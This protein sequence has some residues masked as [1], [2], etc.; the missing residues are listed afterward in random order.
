MLQTSR[1]C[2]DT[3]L[4]PYRLVGDATA[5]AAIQVWL[6]QQDR[7]AAGALMRLLTDY[8]NLSLETLPA[9]LADFV[10][11]EVD[12][13]KAFERP[14]FERGIAFFWKHYQAIALLLG[15]YSLPYCYAAAN[16]AQVLW[17]SERIK[18]D[19]FKR[20]EETGAFVF[21]I[22][23][24]ADWRNERNR[25]RIGKVRLL[26][27]AIR[28]FTL[29]SGRWNDAWGYPIC[30]EDMAGTNL[31]FSYIVLKGLRKLNL[32]ATREEEADY[33]YTWNVIGYMLGVVEPLLPKHTAEAYQLDRAI[34]RRQFVPSEAGRGL[35]KAL[36]KSL[37]K[38]I[39]S[40]SLK[41]L[42]AAQMRYFLGDTVA[43]LIGIPKTGWEEVVLEKAL[44]LSIVAPLLRFAPPQGSSSVLSKYWR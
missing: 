35:T 24:E 5:D 29:H 27:A 8:E 3:L 36:L 16:G 22:M 41:N 6:N 30:Q 7:A 37:E 23:Q 34:A 11:Q 13:P 39:Q 15:T 20:L 25:V 21:G 18:N 4:T 43:D 33:L 17:I 9:P 10:R 44:G 42:P 14:R 26:H 31:T 12:F 2:T 32:T 38:Q 28:W 19:T 40:P 1:P